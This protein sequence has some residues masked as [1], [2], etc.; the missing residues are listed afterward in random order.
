MKNALRLIVALLG[1]LCGLPAFAQVAIPITNATSTGTTVNSTA[2][3]NSSVNAILANTSNTTVPTY[4]VTGGAGTSGQA[5]L[6]MLGQALC[7]MDSTTSGSAWYFVVNS[8]TN[9]GYCHAQSAAP[10]AGT[11]IIG[12]LSSASTTSGA[13][14]LVNVNSYVYGGGS[15][16]GG[17]T[18]TNSLTANNSGSGAASGTT[19]NG[20]SAITFSYNSFGAAPLTSPTFTGVVSIP[21]LTLTGLTGSTQCLQVNSSGVVS[22]TSCGGS[23]NISGLTSGFIPLAGSA[24]TLTANSHLDDG[25]TTA[26][27]ITS[28]ENVVAPLLGTNGSGAGTYQAYNAAHTFYTGWSSAATAN[29][30]ILGFTTA[31]TTGDLVSCTT[32]GINCTL[33]DTGV[34]GSQVVKAAS[35]GVGLAHFAGSTQTVTSSLV[36]IADLSAT[37]TPSSS[38]FLRGDNTWSSS[39]GSLPASIIA[40]STSVGSGIGIGGIEITASYYNDVY[41]PTGSAAFNGSCSSATTTN[42]AI[43]GGTALDPNGGVVWAGY[44]DGSNDGEWIHYSSAT[45]T[46]ITFATSGRGYWGST[47]TTHGSTVPIVLITQALVTSATT[48]PYIIIT[49]NGGQF[50]GAINATATN[51]IGSGQTVNIGPIAQVGTLSFANRG[52]G[53]DSISYPSAVYTFTNNSNNPVSAFGGTGLQY[54]I[55]TQAITATSLT[56]ITNAVSPILHANGTTAASATGGVLHSDCKVIWNQAT[57]GTVQFGVKASAAPTDL[58]VIEQDSPGAYV[59]P[60]YTTITSATTT[61]TSATVTPTAFGTTYASDIRLA[62]NPGTSNNI[63]VQLY[64]LTSSGS[65]TLTIEPGTGCSGWN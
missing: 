31:P 63:S 23:A 43:T 11:W 27:T 33:T 25:V 39:G 46:T 53:N 58:W 44:A 57:G 26:S 35:P 16:G 1:V 9:A 4:I 24:T 61:A 60:V 8:V 17:G 65:D 34:L 45:S 64:A 12:Y 22:G 14:A 48:A 62:M 32:S 36:A 50:Y 6:V 51:N 28:T 47:A 40:G 54:S 59:A 30:N 5:Q 52:N 7:T 41:Q 49:S 21:N 20:A 42:C 55:A 56:A 19:F 18:T 29:N 2:I 13:T 3:I 10:S 15:G 37:G 38:T